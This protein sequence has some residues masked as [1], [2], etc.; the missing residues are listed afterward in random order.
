MGMIWLVAGALVGFILPLLII[1][2]TLS[3]IDKE[4]GRAAA[5]RVWLLASAVAAPGMVLFVWVV[6]FFF[7]NT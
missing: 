1:P 4:Q 2:G 7:V 6:A 5:V 3:R